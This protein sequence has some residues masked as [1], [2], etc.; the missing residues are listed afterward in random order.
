MRDAAL[1]G[2]GAIGG[3]P[4]RDLRHGLR[5]HG[6]LDGRGRRREGDPR[7][8]ARPRGADPAAHRERLG[9]GPDA[10]GHA[11]PDAAGQDARRHR[12]AA[13]GRRPVHL[14]A[15]RPDDRRRLRLVRR[16]RRRQRGRAERPDRLR[17][18]ARVRPGRSRQELP[19]GF[20]RAE[21]L[22]RHGFVDR[23]V[24]R[25]ELRDEL[26]AIL[27]LLP[28]RDG[29]ADA[30]A[31]QRGRARLPAALLPL[32]PGR[33]GRRARGAARPRPTRDACV[34]GRTAA[35]TNGD[36]DERQRPHAP[37]TSGRA[38]S[39]PATCAGRGR[40]SSSRR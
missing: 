22:F 15:V 17:R 39:W 26:A 3:D 7:G 30:G 28:V 19:P 14:G 23:V 12:A 34:G 11:R 6:R 10:G 8:R 13:P 18:G 16:R 33:P 25:A 29:T 9:R 36:A 27:R 38:S 2:T 24:A 21:F 35:P 37:T 32:D 31:R 5:V 4:G 20:Q 1:W 40:S